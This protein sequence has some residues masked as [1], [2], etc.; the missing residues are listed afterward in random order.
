MAD[1]QERLDVL[2][3]YFKL[4]KGMMQEGRNLTEQIGAAIFR[5]ETTVWE[6]ADELFDDKNFR[7]YAV[8]LAL[9]ARELD[10]EA[11]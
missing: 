10:H 9:A 8:A 2:T 7:I 5:R 3:R 1:F 4:H 6:A 11:A